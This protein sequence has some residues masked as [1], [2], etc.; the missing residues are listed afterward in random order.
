[1]SAE[2]AA[3]AVDAGR[4]T[5]LAAELIRCDTRNPPGDERPVVEPLRAVLRE[6]GAEVDIVEPEPGRPS[7]L[8][9]IGSGDGPTLL[10]NGHVDV[11]P[12]VESEWSVPPFAGHVRDGLLYGRGACDMKGGIAAALEGV[13]ACGDAGVVP[14]ANLVFH[15]VADEETGSRVGTEALVAAGLVRADAAVVPEPS[16]L[17]VCVA[18]RGSLLVEIVVRGRAA[19]G[20]D[21]AA[22]HSAV[23]DAARLVSALHLAD[24]GVEA[25]PLLGAPTCNVGIVRGGTAANIVASECRLRADRRV[26]PGQTREEALRTLTESIDAEGDFD[27]DIDVLAFAEGSE[28]DAAHPFVSEVRKAAGQAP[29]RG[30]YLGTDARFLRNQLGIP[31]VV[32]GPGSMTVAHAADEHVPVAELVTAARTFARLY[33]TFGGGG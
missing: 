7:V 24:F 30:L 3:A 10:V 19:H 8:A 28:L 22:G 25:H 5:E 15:L 4:V 31:A 9:R 32:Y 26:L 14:A 20:S 17:Q 18:E 27:Y 23:A 1:M 21:P 29:V 6:L 2:A 33:A 13:R 11:V 12:V 16:E